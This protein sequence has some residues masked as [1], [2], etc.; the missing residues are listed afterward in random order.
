MNIY[1]WEAFKRRLPPTQQPPLALH[2]TSG[3]QRLS[4]KTKQSCST[5][6]CNKKK[7]CFFCWMNTSYLEISTC[8]HGKQRHA[9]IA[10]AH[11]L[12]VSEAT[13]TH[14]SSSIHAGSA[15]LTP[16]TF[17]HRSTSFHLYNLN[18]MTHA[19]EDTSNAVYITLRLAGFCRRRSS[20]KRLPL[21]LRFARERERKKKKRLEV[22]CSGG[23]KGEK[24]ASKV[25]FFPEPK[26]QFLSARSSGPWT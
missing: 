26:C 13:S 2:G 6:I 10:Q 19:E 8:F 17:A 14:G 18:S 23:K 25:T 12:H 11:L 22:K 7:G 3:E 5:A 9:H 16:G 21:V 24:E 4:R 1:T 15:R 20:P